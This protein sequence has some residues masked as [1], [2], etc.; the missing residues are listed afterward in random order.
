MSEGGTEFQLFPIVIEME[1]RW[2]RED[3]QGRC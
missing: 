1:R 3:E 2:S